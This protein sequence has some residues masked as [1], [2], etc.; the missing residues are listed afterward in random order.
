MKNKMFP[1]DTVESEDIEVTIRQA[2]ATDAKAILGL[3]RHIGR[4]TEF[5]TFGPEGLQI[6]VEDEMRLILAYKAASKSIILL[7]ET[8]GQLIGLAS[9]K[10]LDEGRQAHVA[11]LG[12]SLVKEY[13]GYGIGSMM[14]EAQLEFAKAVG[15]EILTLEVVTDNLRAIKLY[16]KFGF[17]KVG[18][19]SQRLKANYHYYDTYIMERVI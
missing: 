8:D 17:T 19:L 15:L 6:S 14:L 7:S 16:E 13:W 5:L 1:F 18:R 11:E 9:I 10:A 12:L 4:E 2:E 3:S